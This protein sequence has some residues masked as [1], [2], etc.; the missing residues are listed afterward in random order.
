MGVNDFSEITVGRTVRRTSPRERDA[1]RLANVGALLKSRDRAPGWLIRFPVP[2]LAR[3]RV[4][5]ISG[6]SLRGKGPIES[7]FL[8]RERPGIEPRLYPAQDSL[9]G[10]RVGPETIASAIVS[11]SAA[12]V[13]GS[14]GLLANSE[15]S[16]TVSLTVTGSC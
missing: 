1:I 7:R 13:L 15:N 4:R 11:A 12:G 10:S 6:L 3:R 5:A 16:L 8:E 14:D 9:S 2:P